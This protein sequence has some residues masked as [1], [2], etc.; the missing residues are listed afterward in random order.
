[1]TPKYLTDR[2]KGVEKLVFK[3]MYGGKISKKM[4]RIYEYKSET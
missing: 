1:M 4:Y 2:L 3:K